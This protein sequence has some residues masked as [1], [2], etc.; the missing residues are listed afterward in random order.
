MTIA[1]VFAGF[2]MGGGAA[3]FWKEYLLF[4]NAVPFEGFP[5]D[6]FLEEIYLF[7]FLFFPFLNF[8]MA[9]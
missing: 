1:I 8:F 6:Q 4:K 3:A 5:V 2:L 7:M 9:G